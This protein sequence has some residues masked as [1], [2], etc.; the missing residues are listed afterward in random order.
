MAKKNVPD[1][2]VGMFTKEQVLKSKR[3]ENRQD[4]L[5]A[6]LTKE[7][8]YNMDE[9]QTML[10]EYLKGKKLLVKYKIA[11]CK[12]VMILHGA[13]ILSYYFWIYR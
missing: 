13:C 1:M 10:D 5:N 9:V 2:N 6:I 4:L 11:P 3:F 7:K 8:L 12:I